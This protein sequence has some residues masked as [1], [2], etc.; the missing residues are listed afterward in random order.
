MLQFEGLPPFFPTRYTSYSFFLSLLFFFALET[1]A[2]V[3]FLSLT[4]SG[5]FLLFF[6][7][8]CV[9]LQERKKENTRTHHHHHYRAPPAGTGISPLEFKLRMLE[10]IFG[11]LKTRLLLDLCLNG[12][13][14]G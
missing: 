1:P 9:S 12:R 13:G 10:I 14:D 4:K 5:L 7:V 3:Q 8:C 2:G 6:F 11:L